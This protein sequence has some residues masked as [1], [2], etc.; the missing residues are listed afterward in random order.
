ML[1]VKIFVT[2]FIAIFVTAMGAGFVAPLLPNYAHELGAGGFQ[3][4]LIFG[5]FSLTRTIFI[6]YFGKR[7][8]LKGRK[9]FITMGLFFYFLVS[10]LYAASN[11]VT[12]LILLRLAQGFASAMVLPVAQAYV[13]EMIPP[14]SE[15][16]LMGLFNVS[17][18]GGLSA[19]PILGGLIKDWISIQASF[20][21]MG[22]LTFSGFLL[23]LILLPSEQT[24]KTDLP[25][26]TAKKAG[27]KELIRVPAIFSILVF[28]ICYTTCIGF[29][30]AF[31]PLL[32]GTRIGLSSSAIGLVVMVNVLIGGLL[33]APMGYAAD[34]FSKKSLT[35]FGGILTIITMLTLDRATSF[36]QLMVIN[37]VLG[38]AGGI[39]LPAIMAIGVIEGR[40][41]K[42]MGS[43]MG[44][45]TL[46]HSIG[47]LL[48][49]LLGGLLLDFF[50]FGAIF[51][52][53]T[54]IMA[55]GTIIFWRCRQV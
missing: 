13:G 28:R 54:V 25:E 21:G 55:L 44:L 45:L 12:A 33:Q 23:C 29:I 20:A 18:L 46:G 53:G 38:L 7:S 32:A 42:A 47:M 9:P 41:S 8:D 40:Q 16:R 51:L 19:G 24:A 1:N 30:W 4:G 6:P 35:L 43:V 22:I 37:S 2:L 17:L 27:Y 15:G 36:W 50:N 10:L 34:R 11:S 48:G 3:I 14:D 31:L 49:P 5:A 26:S 39:S 52:S